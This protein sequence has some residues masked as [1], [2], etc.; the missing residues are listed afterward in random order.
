MKIHL[1]LISERFA[2]ILQTNLLVP[3]GMLDLFVAEMFQT[4]G[5]FT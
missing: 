1:L 3:L 5:L 4:K 2:K